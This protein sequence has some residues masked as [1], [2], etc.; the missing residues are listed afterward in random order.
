MADAT[1]S[2]SRALALQSVFTD[3]PT[4]ARGAAYVKCLVLACLG[5]LVVHKLAFQLSGVLSGS[6][7]LVLLW[8][9]NHLSLKL[10]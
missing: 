4:K 2:G 9:F 5:L 3:T 1:D 8:K 7:K 10:E 6:F